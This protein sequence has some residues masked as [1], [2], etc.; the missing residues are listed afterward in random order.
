MT[1]RTMPAQR[2]GTSRQDYET[3]PDFLAAVAR[4]FGNMHVDLAARAD[5]AKASRFVTP[6]ED[7]LTV[8]WARR[9]PGW[10]GWLNPPFA[11]IDPWAEKCALETV[12][13]A[14]RVHFLT[15]ASVGA[16][17]FSTHVFHRALVLFLQ[18]RI[19]FVGAEDPYPKD[20]MLSVFG[21]GAGVDV[22]R[23]K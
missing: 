12:G 10:R 23:W 19:T 3:P 6:E 8:P 20:C 22:W 14:M 17:W 5:N 18:P 13:D 4:R 21:M 9:F 2:P 15:P 11:D 7:S 1:A 16:V